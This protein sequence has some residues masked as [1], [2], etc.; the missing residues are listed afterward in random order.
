MKALAL[1]LSVGFF[2]A[3]CASTG[4]KRV[5]IDS[6]T[7]SN[8]L[9]DWA[10]STKTS[11]DK[12]N[13]IYLKATHQVR[14]NERVSGCYDLARLDAKEAILSAIA[15]DIRGRMDN[16]QQ[17]I[18][19]NAEVVLSKVRTGEFDGRLTGFRIS[20]EYYE[21]NKIDEIEKIDCY[22]LGEIKQADY[23][24]VK[25]AVIDKVVAVDPK[26]KEAI[27][28]KQVDFFSKENKS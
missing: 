23:D 6:T 4:V 3:G 15:N 13:K 11:W 1:I 12:E 17:S 10:K 18:S 14:G 16:A 5:F 19:E 28:Q 2:L 27:Q 26:I 7:H 21:R 9:P 24:Q 20:E 22:V 25:R 8:D